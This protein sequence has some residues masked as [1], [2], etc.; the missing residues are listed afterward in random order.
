MDS[1]SGRF[2]LPQ[3]RQLEPSSFLDVLW[4]WLALSRLALSLAACRSLGRAS[5]LVHGAHEHLL[6]ASSALWAFAHGRFRR[7]WAYTLDPPLRELHV[8]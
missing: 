3:S 6:S 1:L 4:V 7:A 5:T 8:N 2:Q